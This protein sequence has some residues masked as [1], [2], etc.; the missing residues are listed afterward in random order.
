[1]SK[2]ADR[3]AAVHILDDIARAMLGSADVY[4][5]LLDERDDSTPEELREEAL[6]R[7]QFLADACLQTWAYPD[8]LAAALPEEMLPTHAAM[9]AASLMEAFTVMADDP[10]DDEL[11]SSERVTAWVSH[12]LMI[13]WYTVL[14]GTVDHP[15]I[16]LLLDDPAGGTG[17][18][19]LPNERQHDAAAE[20]AE[21]LDPLLAGYRDLHERY[22]SGTDVRADA[23]ALATVVARSLR[24]AKGTQPFLFTFDGSTSSA[25]F[26]CDTL[27]ASLLR[28]SAGPGDLEIVY[29]GSD[30]GLLEERLLPGFRLRMR[31][32]PE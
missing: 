26:A 30:L 6:E 10:F 5:E 23:I 18:E 27:L 21:I 22:A 12:P 13:R 24:R 25:M 17:D 9:L 20:V 16:G 8:V 19:H 11:P 4:R 15:L 14:M 7:A 29:D 31:S 32:S 3:K 2:R 28:M 1:M